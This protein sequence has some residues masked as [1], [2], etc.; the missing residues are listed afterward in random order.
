M[1]NCDDNFLRLEDGTFSLELGSGLLP[2]NAQPWT[3]QFKIVVVLS[4]AFPL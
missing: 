3:Q 2:S 4:L 1:V